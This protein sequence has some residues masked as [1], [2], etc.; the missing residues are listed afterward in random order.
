MVLGNLIEGA[1]SPF[2]YWT[3]AI[4]GPPFQVIQLGD[5]FLTPRSSLRPDQIRP[6]D[7]GC[8]RRADFNVQL[9]LGCFPF[10][11]RY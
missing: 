8:T 6:H 11:R 10:A 4:Y 3:I 1:C 5:K 9:G 2:A 7:T